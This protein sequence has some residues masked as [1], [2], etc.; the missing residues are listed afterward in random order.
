MTTVVCLSIDRFMY[1]SLQETED[2]YIGMT[3]AKRIRAF[4]GDFAERNDQ[5]SDTS[6]L[7]SVTNKQKK[8]DKSG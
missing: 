3:P 1:I 7:S 6:S 4:N 5:S 8:L 2:T